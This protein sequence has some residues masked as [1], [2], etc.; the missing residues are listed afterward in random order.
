MQVQAPPG[1]DNQSAAFHALEVCGESALL[2]PIKNSLSKALVV[3]EPLTN[4]QAY[5]FKKLSYMH[6][7]VYVNPIFM[8][9]FS[10][11][12]LSKSC[13]YVQN[14]NRTRFSIWDGSLFGT[15]AIPHERPSQLGNKGIPVVQLGYR[16]CTTGMSPMRHRD[17]LVL[18]PEYNNC[19][20]GMLLV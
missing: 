10:F 14:I 2:Y 1:V 3:Q 15:A 7:H 18:Q 11:G 4:Q 6:N 13:D 16:G 9:G 20:T 19:G 12:I 8:Q 17:K 5:P